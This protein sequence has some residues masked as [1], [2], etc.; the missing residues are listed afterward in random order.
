MTAFSEVVKVFEQFKIEE[1]FSDFSSMCVLD[2]D[3]GFAKYGSV[4]Y[5]QFIKNS[6]VSINRTGGV[7]RPEFGAFSIKGYLRSAHVEL[8]RE[9][10]FLGLVDE[11]IWGSSV[12]NRTESYVLK[13]DGAVVCD[14]SLR[15]QSR[16][17]KEFHFGKWI[18]LLTDEISEAKR[19]KADA[20]KSWIYE[21]DE[22]D[23]DPS[24]FSL[25]VDSDSKA[26]RTANSS[27]SILAPAESTDEKPLSSPKILT[28]KSIAKKKRASTR[29]STQSSL[30]NFLMV[31]DAK[32]LS[33]T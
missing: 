10:Q 11:L 4:D 33:F 19:E 26:T 18:Q 24:R 7:L 1:L 3:R 9:I 30:P 22:A 2:A 15:N 5:C 32:R 8:S 20:L 31:T 23:V 14:F 28:Y 12:S 29:K 27:N 25:N 13:I 17:I 21:S 6:K 16:E